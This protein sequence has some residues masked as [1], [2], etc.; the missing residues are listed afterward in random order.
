MNGKGY[1]VGQQIAYPA[2]SFL[3]GSMAMMVLPLVSGKEGELEYTF[4]GIFKTGLTGA[5]ILSFLG[6]AYDQNTAAMAG[7]AGLLAL[8]SLVYPSETFRLKDHMTMDKYWKRATD[9]QLRQLENVAEGIDTCNP[10]R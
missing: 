7:G 5:G 4:R 3:A 8:T 2:V 9:K 1:F 6:G 10:F